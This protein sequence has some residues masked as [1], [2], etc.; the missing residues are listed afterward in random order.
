MSTAAP[1]R[2]IK[3]PWI[4][5]YAIAVL[6]VAAAIAADVVFDR[7]AGADP[8]APLF[9]CAIMFVAWAAGTG[10]ALLATLLTAVAFDYLFLTPAGSFVLSFKGVPHFALFIVAALFVVWLNAGA[11][12]DGSL[13]AACQRNAAHRKRRTQ[14]GGGKSPPGRTRAAG[15][16]RHD[17]GAGGS[18][19]G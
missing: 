1:S 5:D 6:S 7:P 13:A 9:L 16:D 3:P 18:P 10:P 4:P 12:T 17:S 11:E 8:S 15:D 2:W 19:P 14:A